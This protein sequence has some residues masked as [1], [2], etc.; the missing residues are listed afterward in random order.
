MHFDNGD[1]GDS[2]YGLRRRNGMKHWRDGYCSKREFGDW[3]ILQ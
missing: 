2:G 1:E 3:G